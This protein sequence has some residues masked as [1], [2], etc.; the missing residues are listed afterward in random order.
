M[1]DMTEVEQ[2]E[3]ER[4]EQERREQERRAT[5]CRQI[6]EKQSQISSLN[7][8]LSALSIHNANLA[9]SVNKWTNAK[10]AFSQEEITSTVVVKNVFE[11]TAAESV[12]KQN[13]QEITKM[14]GKIK[15]TNDV[16]SGIRR[17]IG[18]VN[19]KIGTLNSESTSLR[20]QL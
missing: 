2:R 16:Q 7:N 11:G 5:I 9:N 19:T 14:D 15:Q 20:N 17:Q 10:Q 6:N 18:K 1:S 12:K 3:A 4:R 8:S 13:E